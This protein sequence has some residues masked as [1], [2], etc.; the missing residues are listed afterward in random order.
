MT[1]ETIQ[2]AIRYV[3]KDGS[4]VTFEDS[5]KHSQMI[6]VTFVSYPDEDRVHQTSYVVGK[7]LWDARGENEQEKLARMVAKWYDEHRLN[8]PPDLGEQT[9]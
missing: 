1:M 4:S 7:E 3:T 8:M 9:E 5:P 6:V 2:D